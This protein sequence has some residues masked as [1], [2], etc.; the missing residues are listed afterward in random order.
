MER[1]VVIRV[2]AEVIDKI[3]D[4]MPELKALTYTATVDYLMRKTLKELEKSET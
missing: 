4:K 1:S 3:K 2:D